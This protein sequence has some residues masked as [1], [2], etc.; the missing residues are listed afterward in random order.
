MLLSRATGS[1]NPARRPCSRLSSGVEYALQDAQPPHLYVIR[2]QLRTGGGAEAAV[3][4][5][6]YYVLDGTVYQAPSL[7]AA[8]SSRMV[9]GGA[10]ALA[11]LLL[12]V[13][14]FRQS[15]LDGN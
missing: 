3:G 13:L 6:C 10:A 9:G 4:Q 5:A 12:P 7:Y 2:R 8:L 11:A 15:S 14:A 1:T